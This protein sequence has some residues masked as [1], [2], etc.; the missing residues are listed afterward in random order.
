MRAREYYARALIAGI[1]VSE[2]RH[3]LPGWILDM[4]KQRAEYDARIAVAKLA[5][6][7]GLP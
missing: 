6:H 1:S 5:R 4:Y 2:A 3:L 7:V